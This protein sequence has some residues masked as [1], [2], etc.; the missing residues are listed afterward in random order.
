MKKTFV[1]LT[2]VCLSLLFG[3]CT[4]APAESETSTEPQV[5]A[6]M[7]S[8][9]GRVLVFE[10][11][12]CAI[13]TEQNEVIV[14]ADVS[15]AGGLFG[16]LHT[17]DRIAATHGPIRETYPAQADIDSL[18]ILERGSERDI[19][20]GPLELLESMGWVLAVGPA[21]ET[22]AEPVLTA[23]TEPYGGET[24]S[25]PPGDTR[26]E[27]YLYPNGD[28]IE[29]LETPDR[30]TV[31][32]EFREQMGDVPVPAPSEWIPALVRQINA[33]ELEGYDPAQSRFTW[34]AGGGYRV[35]LYYGDQVV[36]FN[37]GTDWMISVQY[38]DDPQAR[39]FM[40]KSG[41]FDALI[42]QLYPILLQSE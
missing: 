37:L 20:S 40:D 6:G 8:L 27:P 29:P 22:A 34:P 39:W 9:I 3:S 38:P 11:G 32:A 16:G 42:Q 31:I 13:L 7:Q 23:V 12:S 26:P 36:T 5:Q 21:G 28:R 33:L 4:G 17:G 18:K 14:M 15:T 24:P 30:I 2:V 41:N 19:S 25:V 35:R 1:F 10:S